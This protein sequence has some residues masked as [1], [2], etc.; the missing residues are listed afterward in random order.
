MPHEMLLEPHW[1]AKQ[2]FQL[3]CPPICRLLFKGNI[4]RL[5]T[6]FPRV[7]S[8]THTVADPTPSPYR[9]SSIKLYRYCTANRR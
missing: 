9:Q 6:S 5:R 3:S 2:D 7:N 8:N 1:H 4:L